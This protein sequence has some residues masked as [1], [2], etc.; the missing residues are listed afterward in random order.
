MGVVV[1]RLTLVVLSACNCHCNCKCV[2][3]TDCGA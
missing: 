3:F 2:C 1:G